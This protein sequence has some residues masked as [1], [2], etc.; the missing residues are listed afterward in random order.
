MEI[1]DQK[2]IDGK[3]YIALSGRVDMGSLSKFET[4]LQNLAE[5]GRAVV[6][7]DLSKVNY[8]CSTGLGI[9]M[10]IRRTLVKQQKELRIVIVA[11]IIQEIFQI[12]MLDTVF[13][14]YKSLEEALL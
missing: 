13:P 1:I 6:V 7:I 5:K 10:S 9:L 14:I 3:E 4:A 12:T 11:G 8:I 2:N